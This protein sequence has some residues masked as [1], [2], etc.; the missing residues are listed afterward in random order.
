MLVFDL[1][2][3]GFL[4]Q[5]TVIHCLHII[6]HAT[7][8]AYRF[9]DGFYSDGTPAPR[10]GSIA[11]GVRMLEEADE[12][13]GHNIIRFD[14]PVIVKLFPDFKAPKAFDTL[15]SAQAIWPHIREL[16]ASAMRK[17]KRPAAFT[18][19]HVGSHSLEAWGLR[20]G[21]LK[22]LYTGGWEHFTPDMDDYGAQDPVA[23]VALLDRILAAG[24]SREALD[25]EFDVARAIFMQ[26]RHGVLFDVAAA[27]KLEGELIARHAELR[28]SLRASFKPWV[29]P[30]RKGGV[31]IVVTAGRRTKVRRWHEDGT[32]YTVEFAKGETYEKLQLISFNPG[33]RDHI[34]NRMQ[35][36]FGWTPVEFTENG[37]PKIDETT[38][39]GLD[40]PEAKLLVEYLT[41]DKRLGQLAAGDQAWLKAVRPTGRI[42]GSV[43]TLG[44]VTRRM[45]HSRPNMAQVPK[46]GSPYG[47]ECRSL[48]TVP[49]GYKIVGCDAEGL[50][51]RMLAHYMAKWDGGDYVQTVVNGDKKDGTDIHSVNQRLVGLNSRDSAKTWIY[52]YL[53]GAGN[54]KLGSIICDDFTE[55]KRELFN[56]KHPAGSAR[57]SALIR[58]G[59]RSR[60]SV[61]EGLPAL[62]KLQER[63]KAQAKKK[64][65]TTLDGGRLRVRSQHAALNTLLQGGGAIVMKKALVILVNSLIELGFEPDL[66][67]GRFVR[68]DEELGLVLNVHDEFQMEVPEHLAE[69]IGQLAADSIRR[70]GEAFGLRCPLAGAYDVGTTWADSH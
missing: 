62:G 34:A 1:E 16:D 13:A 24:Y 9:N 60:R 42:H 31:P 65:L 54:L 48:F 17:G 69:E 53:Y 28:D 23:T 46:V 43:N 32:E 4:D 56:K 59:A 57:E 20:L 40:Y 70:A 58:L 38:L 14:I 11:D 25:L 26:E 44:A 55:S 19:K 8:Q 10:D 21:V 36:L 64:Y 49:E 39:S 37:K 27:E 33:S 67:R 45:T 61:E 29:E 51:L 68:G 30:V 2:T 15:I 52:A 5:T 6:D 47:Q 7:G 12:V 41:V 3:N 35:T 18:G 66:L 50:E 63:V 22:A